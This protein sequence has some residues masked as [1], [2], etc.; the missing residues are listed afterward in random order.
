MIRLKTTQEEI[1]QLK[2][3]INYVLEREKHIHAFVPKIK[4]V[5]E[6]YHA[7]VDIEKK[8][9][10]LKSVLEKVTYLRKKTWTKKDAFIINLYTKI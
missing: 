8:N 1:E 6:A 3:E 10:L 5:L 4:N 2:Y 9:L 7:T